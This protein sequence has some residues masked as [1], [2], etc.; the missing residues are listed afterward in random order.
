MKYKERKDILLQAYEHLHRVRGECS[1]EITDE[2]G[3][4]DFT[5]KQIEYLKIIDRHNEITFSRFAEL[6]KTSKPTISEL[7]NRFIKLDCVY[8]EKS[9]DDGRVFHIYLTPKGKE[10]A[11][12]EQTTM[13]KV[14]DRIIASLS[15]D[16]VDILIALFRKVT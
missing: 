5:I 1:C 2:C 3:I 11:R 9:P 10:I 7:I 4:K 14:V 6:T 13:L 8:K 16:E 12:V 15:D